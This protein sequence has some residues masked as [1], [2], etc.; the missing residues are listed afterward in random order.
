MHCTNTVSLFRGGAVTG[1]S[2]ELRA[3][4]A[5]IQQSGRHDIVLAP[6]RQQV[7][8]M[9]NAAFPS[10]TKIANFLIKGE[11]AAG[12]VIVV[13]AACFKT[14]SLVNCSQDFNFPSRSRM[15]TG[16]KCGA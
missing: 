6:Q 8:D 13:D 12:A 9:E 1:K 7:V 4:D 5:E 3:L 11:L 15:G 10:L 16:S 14:G 2:F